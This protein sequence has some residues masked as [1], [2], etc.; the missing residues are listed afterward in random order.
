MDYAESA[1]E[2]LENFWRAKL[3][4]AAVH[5]SENPSTEAKAAYRSVLQTF[6]NLLLRGDAPGTP[7]D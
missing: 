7:D 4:A 5:Y 3:E 2:R 6:A 1:K